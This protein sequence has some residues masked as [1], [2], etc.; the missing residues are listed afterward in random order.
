VNATE[1]QRR[2]SRLEE[3]RGFH[4]RMAKS[5]LARGTK[6]H[7]ELRELK[8]Q[9]AK[10]KRPYVEDLSKFCTGTVIRWD[11]PGY[12][13]GSGY[14]EL[15]YAAVKGGDRWYVTAS[16]GEILTSDELRTRLQRPAV[17]NVELLSSHRLIKKAP[18]DSY[19]V[20]NGSSYDA[21]NTIST[22]P[23]GG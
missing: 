17:K 6:L 12:L 20:T 9:L 21:V 7:K 15:T 13:L 5:H 2:I 19:V 3:N 11:Q 22:N 14:A 1:L 23:F 18:I 16:R 8:E 10:A 4:H